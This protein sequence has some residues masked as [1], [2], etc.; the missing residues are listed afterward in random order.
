[1]MSLKMLKKS[2]NLSLLARILVWCK[3]A[4]RWECPLRTGTWTGRTLEGWCIR[5]RWGQSGTR[6]DPFWD[7][8]SRRSRRSLREGSSLVPRWWREPPWR[9]RQCFHDRCKRE[10]KRW[11]TLPG[12]LWGSN[13]W[14]KFQLAKEWLFARTNLP[15]N[16][17]NGGLC[18]NTSVFN[19]CKQWTW[20]P[21]HLSCRGE[22]Y[23]VC[24]WFRKDLFAIVYYHG[25]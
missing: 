2:V 13:C 19:V 5:H 7:R 3:S 11:Y 18:R 15:K 8:W 20:M 6:C 21:I 23:F 4:V 12:A 9:W 17:L 24:D 14:L 22:R 1:M 25:T 10:R 16:S